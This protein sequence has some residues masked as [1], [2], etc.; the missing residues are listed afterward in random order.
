M[1]SLCKK[2]FESKNI[3]SFFCDKSNAGKHLTGYVSSVNDEEVVIAHISPDGCY[4]GFVYVLID[5]IFRIDLSGR[6]EN[7]ISTL[8]SLKKQKHPML[9]Y[10]HDRLYLSVL[11]FALNERLIISVEVGNNVLSGLVSWFDTNHICMQLI[12]EFGLE[13]GKTQF[14]CASISS[15]SLDTSSEQ[16]LNLLMKEQ[17]RDK[18]TVLLSPN[19]NQP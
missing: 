11:D 17:S 4:D 2:C 3:G 18:G 1:K 5:D 16:S 9:N 12:D 13:D 19:E 7:K 15:I 8:Y 10:S 6:Y 14:L